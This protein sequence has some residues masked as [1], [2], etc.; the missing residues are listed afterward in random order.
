MVDRDDG[1]AGFELSPDCVHADIDVAHA[2]FLDLIVSRGDEV[3]QL[4][5]SY[6]VFP[7]EAVAGVGYSETTAIIINASGVIDTDD[8][9]ISIMTLELGPAA[10]ESG[11]YERLASLA[12]TVPRFVAWFWRS[13]LLKRDEDR[14]WRST[15]IVWNNIGGLDRQG[16]LPERADLTEMN[17]AYIEFYRRFSAMP[18]GDELRLIRKIIAT[19]A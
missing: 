2:K 17:K 12:A 16:D 1:H 18:I 4:G 3:R 8:P 19:L 13:T 9:E 5:V 11:A 10:L 14:Q 6:Y 7:Q 15:S